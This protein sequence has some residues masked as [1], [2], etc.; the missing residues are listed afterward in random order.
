M[1]INLDQAH[2]YIHI[3]LIHTVVHLSINVDFRI[4]YGLCIPYC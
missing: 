3:H 1:S 2:A 4:V